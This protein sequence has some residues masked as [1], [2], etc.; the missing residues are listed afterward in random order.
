[1]TFMTEQ[2]LGCVEATLWNRMAPANI[3]PAKIGPTGYDL[4]SGAASPDRPLAVPPS[5]R[6][7]QPGASRMKPANET[8][9]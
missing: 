7:A 9:R 4:Q 3:G 1:M 5:G 8:G 2:L 6:M